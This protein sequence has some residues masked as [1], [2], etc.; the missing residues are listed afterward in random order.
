MI[1][2]HLLL[3]N[4]YKMVLWYKYYFDFK[5]FVACKNIVLYYMF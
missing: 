4:E 5:K 1:I 2:F 3:K